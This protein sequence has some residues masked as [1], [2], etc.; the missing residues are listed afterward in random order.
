MCSA[1]HGAEGQGSAELGLPMGAPNLADKYWLYGG[2][3]RA[4]QESIRN[5]RAG[6]MPAWKDILGEDKI[7]LLTAYVYN[8]SQDK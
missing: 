3:E 4:V 2:S 8:L 7:H 5:G 1:C 6:V